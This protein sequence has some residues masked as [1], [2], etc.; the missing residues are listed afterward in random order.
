M[1][2]GENR[3]Y[4]TNVM[5]IIYLGEPVSLAYPYMPKHLNKYYKN[6]KY[7]LIL[8]LTGYQKQLNTKLKIPMKR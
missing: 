4:W 8:T 7:I 1:I 3:A 2:I 6:I 5:F